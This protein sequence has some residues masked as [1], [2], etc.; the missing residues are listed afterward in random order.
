MRSC[1]V[2]SCHCSATGPERHL[3]ARRERQVST[4]QSPS[5]C[6]RRPPPQNPCQN[7]P[8]LN[9]GRVVSLTHVG[10]KCSRLARAA[11]VMCIGS[12]LENAALPGQP[13]AYAQPIREGPRCRD[14]QRCGNKQS[15]SIPC[16]SVH[17]WFA[18]PRERKRGLYKQSHWFVDL[19]SFRR[20]LECQPCTKANHRFVAQ[21]L[22]CPCGHFTRK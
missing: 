11:A 22:Q 10:P 7:A 15:D 9:D 1:S 17:F 5:S 13:W 14:E 6:I 16:I 21:A 20:P 18:F 3:T 8:E 4:A 19:G 2:G 12:Y